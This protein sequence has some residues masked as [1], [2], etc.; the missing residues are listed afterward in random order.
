MGL[1]P[2]NSFSGDHKNSND[3]T[4]ALVPLNSMDGMAL[5]AFFSSSP[6]TTGDSAKGGPTPGDRGGHHPSHSPMGPPRGTPK[7]GSPGGRYGGGSGTASAPVVHA[8]TPPAVHASTPPSYGHR[9][10]AAPGGRTR[11]GCS[12][13][14]LAGCWHG[15][16]ERWR[17]HCRRRTCRPASRSWACPEEGPWEN[18]MD[19]GRHDRREWDL[20]WHYPRSYWES[21]RRTL[22]APCR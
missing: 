16:P 6:N 12:H 14:R 7:I 18:A 20:P 13:G 11:A 1:T 2:I 10:P 21:S 17:C 3:G 4:S 9:R 22:A 15:R 19:G 5:R 8:S